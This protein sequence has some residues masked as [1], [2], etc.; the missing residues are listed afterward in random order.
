MGGC[1]RW[2]K[3]KAPGALDWLDGAI[4]FESGSKVVAEAGYPRNP[5]GGTKL[6]LPEI[7][8]KGLEPATGIEP[9]TCGLRISD[10]LHRYSTEHLTV[11]ERS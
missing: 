9:A 6:Q 8:W 4:S 1:G 5:Q 7:P 3:K 2:L 11:A 10:G